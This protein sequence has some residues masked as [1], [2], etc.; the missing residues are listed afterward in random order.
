MAECLSTLSWL[1]EILELRKRINYLNCIVRKRVRET[2]TVLH[3]STRQLFLYYKIFFL[4][5]FQNLDLTIKCTYELQKTL[6]GNLL[7]ISSNNIFLS[8]V[9][10]KLKSFKPNIIQN[11][12][13]FCI[14]ESFITN[15]SH[16]VFDYKITFVYSQRKNTNSKR[17]FVLKTGLEHSF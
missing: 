11:L 1:E 14:P 5:S 8:D 4:G 2:F 3:Y 15:I 7:L 9:V 16:Q 17:N 12:I 13:C 6:K 10:S